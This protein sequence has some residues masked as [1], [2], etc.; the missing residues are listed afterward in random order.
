M[1]WLFVGSLLLSALVSTV[2]V[3]IL[4]RRRDMPGGQYLMHLST[5]LAIWAFFYACQWLATGEEAKRI[6][7]NLAFLGVLMAPA[8]LFLFAVRFTRPNEILRWHVFFFILIEPVITYVLIWTDPYHG[9]FYNRTVPSGAITNTGP[10]FW[11]NVIYLYALIVAALITLIRAWASMIAALRPQLS[12]IVLGISVP[13]VLNPVFILTRAKYDFPDLTPVAFVFSG[14]LVMLALS[15][16]RLFDVVPVARS[17]LFER[18]ADAVIVLDERNRVVDMNPA[19]LQ[20]VGK[21]AK[22]I[23]GYPAQQILAE[24]GEWFRQFRD[25]L[26]FQNEV[27]LPSNPPLILDLRITPL[28]DHRG[29][30]SGRL[31]VAR[32]ITQRKQAEQSE[33]E[34]R[35]LTEALRDSLAALARSHSLDEVLDQIL[36]QVG[37]VVPFDLATLILMSEDGK[38]RLI[39]YRGYREQGLARFVHEEKEALVADFPSSRYML[40]TKKAFVIPDTENS[41]DWIKVEGLEQLRSY[42]AAPIIVHDKVIGFLNLVSFTPNFFSQVHADRLQAFADEAAIAI[43]NARLL[44]ETTARAEQMTALFEIGLAITSGLNR[45]SILQQLLEE[46]QKVLPMDAFLVALF[47]AE[48]GLIEYPLFYDHGKFYELPPRYLGE[49]AGLSGHIIKTRK[50]VYLPDV[51]DEQITRNYQI[52]H[53]GGTPTRSYVGVPMAIGE[54]TVG[55][56]S[57]QSYAPHAYS[58][59]QIRL[60]ETIATQAAVA[61]ENA[62]L[63]EEIRKHAEEMTALVEIGMAITSGLDQSH[64]LQTLFE[65]CRQVLPLDAFYIAAYSAQDGEMSYPLAYE[66]GQYLQVPPHNINNQNESGLTGYVIRQG[67]TLYIPDIFSPDVEQIYKISYSTGSPIRSYLAVP[68]IIRDRI[69]GVISVQSYQVDAYSPQQIRL[70]EAIATQAAIA[71]ENSRLYTLAQQEILER[72]AAEERYRALFDQSQDAI[73]IIGFDGRP[74]ETNWRAS[75]MLGYSS[76]ELLSL[77]LSD[78]YANPAEASKTIEELLKGTDIP[79]YE[80]SFRT[81]NGAEISVELNAELVHDANG[82]PLHIQMT[83]RDITARKQAERALQDANE[84]LRLQLHQIKAL[85]AQLREQA[86][87]DPLTGLFNRRYMEESL[88]RELALADRQKSPVSVIMMDMDDFKLFNDTYGHDAG[89]FLLK[90]LAEFL[91]REIRSSDICCRYGGEEFLVV[92]PG[93]EIEKAQERAEKI[94][95]VFEESSYPFMGTTLRAT[96]SV[97]VASYPQHG[98]TILELIHAADRAMYQAKA[99]G[100]NRVCLA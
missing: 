39:R 46:C 32:D 64:V 69:V 55:V 91:L 43:E 63:F 58:R 82:N 13:A 68:M 30:Y 96:L 23:I 52:F 9:L 54:R 42:V 87:R 62:R 98:K 5:G 51:T 3:G 35:M 94:C 56:I 97:G 50:T 93:A 95:R 40:D 37:R 61:L 88:R 26:V 73:F 25:T 75:T 12:M 4:W 49:N 60:L 10:W 1:N 90:K 74:V 22:E 72:R 80:T 6:W 19:A 34:Q 16:F 21:T 67:R 14:L 83:V 81:K 85:Q 48:S 99:A 59:S 33:H 11:I 92:M 86:I 38:K 77:H 31:I 7:L 2:V 84:K 17:V 36:D 41:S 57:M 27:T 44:E 24:Y 8:S 70:L 65:Q 18:M 15:R 20:L 76:H 66:N 29:R 78:I 47:N 79:L 53:L 100:K 71:F 89:D 28:H 45:E